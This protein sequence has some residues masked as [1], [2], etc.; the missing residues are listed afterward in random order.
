MSNIVQIP[1]KYKS[2]TLYYALVDEEDF[3]YLMQFA[4]WYLSV[5]AKTFYVYSLSIVPRHVVLM[6]RF[7]LNINDRKVKTE[8]INGNGLHNYRSNI[9]IKI[10]VSECEN[11]VPKHRYAQKIKDGIYYCTFYHKYKVTVLYKNRTINVGYFDSQHEALKAR[12]E[13]VAKLAKLAFKEALS[14]ED[15]LNTDVVSTKPTKVNTKSKVL[16]LEDL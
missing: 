9:R 8:H 16:T 4:P 5:S 12:K 14:I 2:A 13:Q 10:K 7:L 6:H 3:D 1:L 11:Y 15:L